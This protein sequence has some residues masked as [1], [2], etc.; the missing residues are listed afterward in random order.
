VTVL[1]AVACRQADGPDLSKVAL[2]D[3]VPIGPEGGDGF[4]LWIMT[5]DAKHQVPITRSF[6]TP[7]RHAPLRVSSFF[8]EGP[9]D[10]PRTCWSC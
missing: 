10:C 4:R 5:A 2:P 6:Y 9:E 8:R 7:Q 1:G 3:P